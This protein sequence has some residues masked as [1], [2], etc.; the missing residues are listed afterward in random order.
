MTNNYR[1]RP[2]IEEGEALT[3]YL[4]RVAEAN[5]SSLRTMI[6]II[7]TQNR[8]RIESKMY[9]F[10]DLLPQ[11]QVDL[12]LLS[13]LL[14]LSE[15]EILSHTYY[16]VLDKIYDDP[17]GQIEEISHHISI[18]VETKHR[19]F[20]RKCL[21]N[22]KGF[23]LIWQIKN[24]M[25][26]KTHK[27]PLESICN[28]C[29]KEQPFMR[30]E[31]E[32]A[33]C[34][35]CQCSFNS[36]HEETKK[37][38]ASLSPLYL[39]TYE[40][41]EGLMKNDKSKLFNF[42]LS[43]QQTIAIKILYLAQQKENKY[44]M[45]RIQFLPKDESKFLIR[46]I[47]GYKTIHSFSLI[48]ILIRFLQRSE[49]SFETFNK[50]EAAQDYI[51]SLTKEKQEIQ[52]GNCNTPWC[53]HQ[54]SNVFMIKIE[55]SY[56][57]NYYNVSICTSCFI[58]YGFEIDTGEWGEI[59]GN[60][61]LILNSILPLLESGFSRSKIEK[62]IGISSN[63]INNMLGYMYNHSLIPH[64][65]SYEKW[66]KSENDLD[67]LNTFK[68]LKE[69]SSGYR[70]KMLVQAKEQYNWSIFD[71]YKYYQM[72]EIQLYLINN[73]G[74]GER[75]P[76]KHTNLKEQLIEYQE[77]CKQDNKLFTAKEFN[78]SYGVSPGILSYYSLN[79]E[80]AV[81]RE[82]QNEQVKLI[83]FEDIWSKA[84]NFTEKM[85]I[86]AKPFN[87][88]DV[89]QA[90]GKRRPWIIN[91]LMEFEEWIHQQVKISKQ[92]QWKMKLSAYKTQIKKAIK[93]LIEEDL[94]LSKVNIA[95]YSEI[96]RNQFARHSELSLFCISVIEGDED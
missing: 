30:E 79:D 3:S 10:L 56:I 73:K 51:E 71:F 60:I 9:H 86:D 88:G 24:V 52:L 6:H 96:D 22:S 82:K 43:R 35:F 37:P 87:C 18:L 15:N 89:Y 47:R 14:C 31:M 7:N 65:I 92:Q 11:R 21:I 78:E 63:N 46:L 36:V 81:A 74:K 29:G 39:K 95:K 38:D 84:R 55:P 12:T 85:L 23:K 62:M 16:P 27:E 77:S 59:G 25:I 53:N 83:R 58:T 69:D 44:V 61:P 50:V 40:I 57:K 45:T 13:K 72:P 91:N 34:V 4:F 42:E 66:I 33:N 1:V 94:L 48:G 75:E 28:N 41:W 8:L 70:L 80:L 54:S 67:V 68:K 64:S 17:L 5:G 2:K 93:Q 32:S 26:C 20:C 19:K 90:I 76:R 49:N